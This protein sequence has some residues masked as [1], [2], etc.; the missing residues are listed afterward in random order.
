MAVKQHKVGSTEVQEVKTLRNKHNC[1]PAIPQE[2]YEGW[3]MLESLPDDEA[4]EPG[5][6]KGTRTC[7]KINEDVK[8]STTRL[9]TGPTSAKTAKA[10]ACLLDTESGPREASAEGSTQD[11]SGADD[12]TSNNAIDSLRVET[13]M[14]A[15]SSIQYCD[16]DWSPSTRNVPTSSI[17]PVGCV[18]HAHRT[19]VPKRRHGRIKFKVPGQASTSEGTKSLLEVLGT[20]TPVAASIESKTLEPGDGERGDDIGIANDDDGDLERAEEALLAGEASQPDC[21]STDIKDN[22]PMSSKPPT[23]HVEHLRGI[24]RPR[25]RRGRIKMDPC[26]HTQALVKCLEAH[27]TTLSRLRNSKD[28][29]TAKRY[30]FEQASTLARLAQWLEDATGRCATV[31]SAIT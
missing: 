26:Y 24:Y 20:V 5:V 30:I 22:I 14:L 27:R 23:E 11:E 15:E 8:G 12:A 17:P 16:R 3:H 28:A 19:S 25:R 10:R 2:S 21:R 4:R 13:R 6:P 31:R 9:E 1:A 18:E 7:W 29:W